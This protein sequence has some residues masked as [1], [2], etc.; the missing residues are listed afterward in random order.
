MIVRGL[1]GVCLLI[2][3]PACYR[4]A[5]MTRMVWI[6]GLY[7]LVD[8]MTP[9]LPGAFAFEPSSSTEFASAQRSPGADLPLPADAPAVS[10]PS[11]DAVRSGEPVSAACVRSTRRVLATWPPP[12]R[13]SAEPADGDPSAP[14]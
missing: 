1:V 7:L 2:R 12:L 4:P 13:N 10:L 11:R 8:F 9:S 5:A 14:V 6:I 3:T